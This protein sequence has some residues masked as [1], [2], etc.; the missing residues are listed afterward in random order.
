MNNRLNSALLTVSA[1][2]A[3][4]LLSVAPAFA[5]T[6]TVGSVDYDVTFF[7]GS[8]NSNS[9]LFQNPPAGMLPWWGNDMLAITFAQHVYDKLGLGPTPGNG[10]VFAYEL[11]GTDILGVSQDLGD[12]LI[13]YPET[14]SDTSAV[15]YAIATPLNS[16]LASVPAPLPVLGAAAAFAWSRQLRKRIA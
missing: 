1:I 13:Q 16:A 8:Y 2:V 9:S 12:L 3:L 5:L 4:P 10:P 6:V 15:K 7:N 14:I 11:S